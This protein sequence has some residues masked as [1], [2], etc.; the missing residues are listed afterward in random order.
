MTPE[1]LK[2]ALAAYR[3]LLNEATDIACR[4]AAVRGIPIDSDFQSIDIDIDEGTVSASW[5]EYSRGC[6]M[7]RESLQFPIGYLSNPDSVE[8]IETECI[9]AAAEKQRRKQEAE[10]AE[11]KRLQEK[12]ERET[13]ERLR[14]KYG[15]EER[16]S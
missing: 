15:E 3:K 11:H 7:G 12:R 5:D 1:E 16:H 13:Y 10:K 6:Y 8:A 4:V 9:Q 2:T 14:K